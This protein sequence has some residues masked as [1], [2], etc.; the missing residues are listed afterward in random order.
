VKNYDIV[1]VSDYEGA[2]IVHVCVCRLIKAY[3]GGMI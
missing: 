1:D 2:T 3:T